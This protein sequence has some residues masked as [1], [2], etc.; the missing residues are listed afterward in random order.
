MIQY[1][2]DMDAA[3]FMAVGPAGAAADGAR[4]A[5]PEDAAPRGGAGAQ[6]AH[7]YFVPAEHTALAREISATAPLLAPEQMVVLETDRCDGA[8][9]SPARAWPCT[10]GRRTT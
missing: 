4:R 5:R 9:A 3:L 2:D 8:R 10:C 7:P 6:G 1:L